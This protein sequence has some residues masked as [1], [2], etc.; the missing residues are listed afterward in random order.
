MATFLNI[1]KTEWPKV[2]Y[3]CFFHHYREISTGMC[4]Y[5]ILF[6]L[7]SAYFH[8]KF[9]FSC[10]HVNMFAL[11]TVQIL[12]FKTIVNIV[13]KITT[14]LSANV[15]IYALLARY[16]FLTG[17]NMAALS[18]LILHMVMIFHA[19]SHVKPRRVTTHVQ[20]RAGRKEH[21][22]NECRHSELFFLCLCW[23]QID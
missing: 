4:L 20:M 14:Y 22:N 2:S 19:N 3:I 21:K 17:K 16:I 11:N 7:M 23:I 15:S 1:F 13:V 5:I 9:I 8:C 10:E 6:L 18:E 12:C